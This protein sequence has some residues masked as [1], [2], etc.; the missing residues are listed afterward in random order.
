MVRRGV[1]FDSVTDAVVRGG[2]TSK[3]QTMR[4]KILMGVFAL[5]LPAGTLAAF[6][7]VASAKAPQNPIH[8]SGVGGGG[9]GG[10][11]TF[12]TPI[13]ANG[14]ATSSKTAN[15]TTIS[16][17]SFNCGGG[18]NNGSNAG[19]TITGGKNTKLSKS[20]PRYNK[21]TGVKYV[22]GTQAEFT[23]AGGSLKKSLKSISFTING[24]PEVFQAKSAVED[25][26]P[27]CTGEVGFTITGQVKAPP[28][29]D[30]TATITA[31]LGHD[32]GPGT[33]NSFGV[34]LFSPTATIVTAQI[35]TAISTAQHGPRPCGP[36]GGT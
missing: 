8:C 17:G 30:K 25:V 34:D 36:N 35:D 9:G 24:S 7:S 15:A 21:A 11:V 16:G 28:Y 12:G 29:A 22:T 1:P 6:S 32:T 20:D 5:A 14:V 10:V 31:C 18:T 19:S 23:A 33:T 27:P 2:D 4:R 3:E 13:S 26:G